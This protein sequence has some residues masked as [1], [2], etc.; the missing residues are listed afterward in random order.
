M[1]KNNFQFDYT[2]PEGEVMTIV[3]DKELYQAQMTYMRFS[4]LC[5]WQKWD[6]TELEKDMEAAG[7]SVFDFMR[8]FDSGKAVSEILE[9]K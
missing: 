3:F 5:F 9:N 2:T 6:R 4:N 1:E 8:E 7:V